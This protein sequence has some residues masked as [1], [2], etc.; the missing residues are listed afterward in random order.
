MQSGPVSRVLS[1]TT[2]Y[3][4]P[5]LLPVSSAQPE[6]SAG[7]T[8][9]SYLRLLRMGFTKPRCCQHAGSLLHYRFSFSLYAN[10]QVRVFFSAALSVGSPRLAVSQHPALWSPDF[11]HSTLPLS[12]TGTPRLS[13]PLC[14]GDC[15]TFIRPEAPKSNN[16]QV[17]ETL[18]VRGFLATC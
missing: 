13:G 5:A 17:N 15:I 10:A 16:L 2:I 4:L 1:R 8:M 11:P 14:M 12:W 7:H 6:R 9:R 3:L 18:R